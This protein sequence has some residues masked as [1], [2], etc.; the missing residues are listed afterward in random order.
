MKAARHGSHVDM[1]EG[2]NSSAQHSQWAD[3]WNGEKQKSLK[4]VDTHWSVLVRFD[5]GVK[6]VQRNNCE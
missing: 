2:Q 4:G 6:S 1:C 3:T 5:L